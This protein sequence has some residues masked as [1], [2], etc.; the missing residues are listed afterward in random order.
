VDVPDFS[1]LEFYCPVRPLHALFTAIFKPSPRYSIA[2]Q[3]PKVLASAIAV[4]AIEN[5][6]DC[7][8]TIIP[9]Q[10]N[11]TA[12]TGYVVQFANTLNETDVS[13]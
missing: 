2:N 8:K 10:S 5:N 1:F 4:I 6:Y 11:L 12:A 13:R 9:D 7:S 3:D